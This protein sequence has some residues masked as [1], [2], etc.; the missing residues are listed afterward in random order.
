MGLAKNQEFGSSTL[1]EATI[2]WK[3]KSSVGLLTAVLKTVSVNSVFEFEPRFL[4]HFRK[5]AL[6]NWQIGWL[7][8]VRGIPRTGVEAHNPNGSLVL[9][10]QVRQVILL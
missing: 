3:S 4:R 5:I 1:P 8:G 10:V 2:L 7:L 9:S 6:E